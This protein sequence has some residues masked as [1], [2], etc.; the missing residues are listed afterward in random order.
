MPTRDH[1]AVVDDSD[2]VGEV[3]GLLEVLRR[4]QQRHALR[5]Q[6]A[7]ALPHRKAAARVEAG[8][9]LIEEKHGWR[10]DQRRGEVETTAHAARVGLRGPVGGVGEAELLEQLL[11]ARARIC[12]RHAVEAADHLEVLAPGQ[13]LVDRRVLAGEADPGAQRVASRT[14]SRP[15][16][17]ARPPSGSSSVVKIRT[18]VVLPAPFGPS[19]PNTVPAATSRSRPSSASVFP[20]RLTSPSARIAGRSLQTSSTQQTSVTLNIASGAPT[21]PAPRADAQPAAAIPTGQET[22]VPPRPQ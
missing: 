10:R 9:R 13:Q 7:D 17:S 18:A 1:A 20:K 3:V 8:R 5:A 21:A 6:L 11:R 16:T 2:Q 15:A 22:P 4:H 19:R 12:S 14:Q